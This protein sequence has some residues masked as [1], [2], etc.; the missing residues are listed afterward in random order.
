M[1]TC[2]PR[3]PGCWAC[4][5]QGW[6][7]NGGPRSVRTT[8]SK[9]CTPARDSKEPVAESPS[10]AVPGTRDHPGN[11]SRLEMLARLFQVRLV[12]PRGAWH[13]PR[14]WES[15]AYRT[16]APLGGPSGR[17]SPVAAGHRLARIITVRTGEAG[18]G[19]LFRCPRA[20]TT[21]RGR[22]PFRPRR[23]GCES[24]RGSAGVL[25]GVDGQVPQ[26][27]S[28]VA[29]VLRLVVVMDPR[30]IFGRVRANERVVG[31]AD[32]RLRRRRP[33][34]S[35]SRAARRGVAGPSGP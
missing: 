25:F 27:M 32:P 17:T 23:P 8:E 18:D 9:A 33:Q 7:T 11:P 34:A 16:A 29:V 10:E 19:G 21:N 28:R 13:R 35:R 14:T 31:G 26:R 15:G 5:E 30:R 24:L 6:R 4:R 3:S 22:G 2:G 1:T 20:P 12:L